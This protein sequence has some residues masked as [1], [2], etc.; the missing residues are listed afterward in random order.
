MQIDIDFEVFKALT[1]LRHNETHSYNSVLR[2][3][4]K[5]DPAEPYLKKIKGKI[6]GGR[7]LPRVRTH[8]HQMTAAASAIAPMKF[9]MLRSK[10]VAMRRQSLRRQNMR[11]MTLRCL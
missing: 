5:L 2:E 3:L 6:L 1:A 10:R 8:N 11:S 7:F 4:L 9:L